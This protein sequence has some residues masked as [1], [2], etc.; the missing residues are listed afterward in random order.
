MNKKTVVLVAGASAGVFVA[1]MVLN[2]LNIQSSDGFGVDDFVTALVVVAA[3]LAVDM[4]F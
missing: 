1:P 4:V 2:A 3:V